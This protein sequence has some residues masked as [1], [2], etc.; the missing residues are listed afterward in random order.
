MLIALLVWLELVSPNF[1]M[2]TDAG[3]KSGRGVLE[4]L[5]LVRRVFRP[6]GAGVPVRVYLFRS[7]SGLRPFRPSQTTRGFFQSGPEHNV[8]ALQDVGV[9]TPRIAVHE[10]V[11]L[12]LDRSSER[13]PRWFEEGT[14]EFYSTLESA[15][16]RLLVGKPVPAHLRMLRTAKWLAA[17]TLFQVD[18]RSPYYSDP[19]R[20][21]IFYAQSWALVHMLNLSEEYRAGM[22]RLSQGATFFE[23]FGRSREKAI[24]DLRRYIGASNLPVAELE[25]P[26]REPAA[27]T[28][29]P[30]DDSAASLL[31]A[32]LYLDAGKYQEAD[33]LY[34]KAT[35]NE[36]AGAAEETALGMTALRRRDYPEA[37]RRL[38]R[39]IE[40]GSSQSQTYFEYAMLLRET[41]GDAAQVRRL[42]ERSIELNPAHPE[43]HF[44]LG[45]VASKEKRPADAVRHFDRAASIL[46]RQS[47]FWHALALACHETGDRGCA[48]RAASR[49]VDN[50]ATPEELT[51]AQAA[52][53]LVESAPE[54]AAAPKPAV[55][56]PPGWSGPRGGVKAE[57]TLKRI[58]C[59]GSSARMLIDTAGGVLR[60]FIPN[61]G[62]ILLRDASALTFEFTCG[63][64]KPRRVAIEYAPR[65]DA[66]LGTAGDVTSI[67]F[68]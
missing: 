53:R 11:H 2:A 67:A 34:R 25:A 63:E 44:I 39:A 35:G 41:G 27:A 15:G 26:T 22:P 10:Y 43:A 42:L 4:S 7:E 68:R 24:Y 46:P 5:E 32:E 33:R 45:L 49:A 19:A 23:A 18:A 14:A 51:M 48:R 29:R 57:G 1:R 52:V 16:G 21:G 30:L 36:P 61:P 60:V 40:L 50:A 8:I 31:L 66:R 62:E 55:S 58:D 9:E 56:V 20:V 17:E 38:A 37:R 59:F 65:P 64:Q 6:A 12:V 54:P 47:S 28:A 3:E 13:L